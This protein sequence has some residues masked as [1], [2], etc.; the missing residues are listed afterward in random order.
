MKLEA[1]KWYETRGGGK[2]FVAFV[3]PEGTFRV[4]QT[5]D[6]YLEY[7][8]G[9]EK[10]SWCLNGKYWATEDTSSCDLVK[11]FRPKRKWWL[12]LGQNGQL[13]SYFNSYQSAELFIDEEGGVDELVCVE[14]VDDVSN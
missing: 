10:C 9:K 5:C 8:E 14:E 3:Y 7:A 2:A 1:G 6:G 11:P 13:M 12:V 4:S